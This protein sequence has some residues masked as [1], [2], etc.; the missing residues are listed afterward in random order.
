M[1]K[2]SDN[3]IHY[4]LHQLFR[5]SGTI[6]S[7]ESIEILRHPEN[8]EARVGFFERDIV[9]SLMSE[10]DTGKLLDG[11]LSLRKVPSFDSKIN[12]PVALTG[13][14]NEFAS[15]NN[16]ELRINA[17]IIT[18]SFVMLSRY[19]ETL[20]AGRDKYN[21]FEYINSLASKYDFIEIPIVDEY[22]MLL[23]KWL[24]EFI[25]GLEFQRR[26]SIVIPTH[27]VDFLLR[28]GS[29]GKNIKTIIGGDL[30]ARRSFHIAGRSIR[31]WR[32]ATQDSKNDPLILAIK[33]IIEV[34]E[35][36]GL[37][38]IF[39]FKG[40]KKGQKDCTYD[41]SIPEVKYCMELVSEKGMKVGMH[42]G[43]DSYNNGQIFRQE[44]ED[45]ES[46]YGS[47]LNTGRQHFLRYD[48]NLTLQIWQDNGIESDSTLGYPEREGFRCGT[49]H[50]YYLYDLKNDIKS[51]VKEK[52]LIVM[53]GTLFQYRG[54]N[55]E[56]SVGSIRKLYQRCQAVEG[57]MVILW[58]NH[59]LFRDY[60]DKFRGVYCKF[61][62]EI[63]E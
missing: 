63:S 27:D 56:K 28:F 1:L 46:V 62:E 23:R 31:E 17:D 11:E 44:K 52:P 3:A 7:T 60:E 51:T 12:I 25:P 20:T 45:L 59:S 32:A 29:L 22:A 5:I 30:L 57:D 58:H 21:R 8:S 38:S 13:D 19:D 16:G 15:I 4:T 49:C 14:K 53:E 9:F 42:G 36:A 18:L 37:T 6:L 43:F 2:L 34:S 47:S 41:V 24:A 55:I 54:L 35:E 33:R 40:S 10:Y 39:H 48:I 26:N 50:E 61:I